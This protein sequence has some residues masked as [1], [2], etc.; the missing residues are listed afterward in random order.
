LSGLFCG[1]WGGMEWHACRV[2]DKPDAFSQMEELGEYA[3][4]SEITAVMGWDGYF[5]FDERADLIDMAREYMSV[6]Q[7]ESCDKCV[8]CRMGTR[9]AAEILTRI[10]E[11]G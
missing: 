5:V 11:R 2:N 4:G 8:P 1:V 3:P 10:A 6:V 7:Q 9:V